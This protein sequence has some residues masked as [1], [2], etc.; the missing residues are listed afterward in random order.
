MLSLRVLCTHRTRSCT[1]HISASGEEGSAASCTASGEGAAQSCP[2]AQPA[3]VTT[4]ALIIHWHRG[5]LSLIPHSD[6]GET[7]EVC[8][9]AVSGQ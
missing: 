4:V 3:P 2:Q 7:L 1:G 8:L 6:L 9:N 5:E